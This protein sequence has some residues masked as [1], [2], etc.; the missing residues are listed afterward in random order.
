MDSKPPAKSAPSA[1][2][3][4]LLVAAVLGLLRLKCGGPSDAE[5]AIQAAQQRN[6]AMGKSLLLPPPTKP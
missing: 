4:T 1:F 6:E 5:L 2:L 3:I